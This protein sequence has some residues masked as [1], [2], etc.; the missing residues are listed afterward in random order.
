MLFHKRFLPDYLQMLFLRKLKI[1]SL[2]TLKF[3]IKL[4]YFMGN[5]LMESGPRVG[6]INTATRMSP[7]V[8]GIEV[9]V[10]QL[11][12]G[13]GSTNKHKAVWEMLCHR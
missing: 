12:R 6:L 3:G 4:P 8:L 13:N 7:S 2:R 9:F 10:D 11:K 5:S 1:I